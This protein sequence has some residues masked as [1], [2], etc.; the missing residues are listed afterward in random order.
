VEHRKENVLVGIVPARDVPQQM[1]QSSFM[2]G[3]C[4]SLGEDRLIQD[5]TQNGFAKSDTIEKKDMSAKP[6]VS[7]ES[8]N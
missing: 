3:F 7:F 5:S 6:T 8:P 1:I 4:L 2:L